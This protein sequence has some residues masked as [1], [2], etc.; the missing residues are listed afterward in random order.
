MKTFDYIIIGAGIAGCSVAYFLSKAGKKVLVLEQ[1]KDL[2]QGASYAAGGFISPLLG[3]QNHFKT[4]VNEALR[5][6]VA[7][8]KEHFKEYITQKGVLR[9]PKNEE[10]ALKFQ[11]YI[12]FIDVEFQQQEKGCFF[13]IGAQVQSLEIL[14]H[15]LTQSR[16]EFN[17]KV[18]HLY[19]LKEGYSID[20]T[21][22]ANKVIVTTGA[23]TKLIPEPYFQIRA[24]WGQR[25]DIT[26]TTNIKHNYHKACSISSAYK[27]AKQGEYEVS[28]GATHHRFNCDHQVCQLCLE[29]PNLNNFQRLGQ[30]ENFTQNNTKNLLQKAN[31]IM[32]FHDVEVK[33]VKFGARACSVDYFPMVGALVDSKQTLQAFPYLTKG[34]HVPS[35]RWHYYNNLFVLNGLGGRGFV[36]AP[37]LAQQLAAFLLHNQPLQEQ[38]QVNRLFK[39][40]VKRLN[41]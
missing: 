35:S 39:R 27:S 12:P 29:Q 30:D 14:K 31:D 32:A 36:L 20:D 28:I 10:D 16:V 5:F 13:P 8:Y 11:S 41:S 1:N 18:K 2:Q 9:I 37:Y 40:Y 38:I 33:S 4:L 25:I 7:F 19:A 17:Y 6:S 21:F 15:L 34:T 26:T 23:N 22:F 3:K 24:V